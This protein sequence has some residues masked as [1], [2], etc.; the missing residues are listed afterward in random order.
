LGYSL[1]GRKVLITGASA[2][3]GRAAAHRFLAEGA[4][5]W[6]LARSRDRLEELSAEAGGPPRLVPIVA[7]VSDGPRME[8]ATGRILS[9]LGVPDVIVANAGIGL[10]ARFENTKDADLARVFEVN[11]FGLIRTLRP[12]VRPMAERGSGRILLVSSIVGK[13][14]VPN[15]TAYSGSKFAVQGI[16]ETVRTELLHSGVKV[17]V[18][19]P[20]STESEFRDRTLRDGPQQNQKRLARH[21]ADSVAMAIVKMVRSGRREK[22]LTVEG[23]LLH[24]ANKFIPGILDR[25]LYR[26][27][28][29]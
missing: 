29:K 6:A 16:A 7:D 10:D 9:E 3:I 26:V 23:K 11:V 28:L 2:G 8:E 15:Y 24:Y 17:G 4:D 5:V 22:G 12:F 25:I 14:G 13:R 19:C 20:A 21:S 1:N 18:V 27:M